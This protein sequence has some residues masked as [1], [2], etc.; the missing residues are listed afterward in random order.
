MPLTVRWL[1]DHRTEHYGRE[2][3]LLL[4]TLATPQSGQPTFTDVE[5]DQVRICD[6]RDASGGAWAN[7]PPAGT[8]A[9]DPALGRVYFG[10]ALPTGTVPVASYHAGLAV[11]VGAR[12][13]RRVPPGERP[14]ALGLPTA[15]PS[16]EVLASG[17]GDLTQELAA[18]RGGGT[19]RIQD[20]SRWTTPVTI[21]TDDV[22]AGQPAVTVA[23]VSDATARPVIDDPK[24]I[25]L[26]MAPGSTVV[27]DGLMVSAGPVVLEETGQDQ[28]RTVILRDCTLVPGLDRT[29]TGLPT[30]PERASLIVL[31]PFATVVLD[32]CV[33]GPVVAVEGC[34]V[35]VHSCVVDAGSPT[36]VALAGRDPG[37]GP[38]AD[39]HAGRPG[40]RRRDR[41]VGRPAGSR[42]PPWS[43]G[44]TSPA[45]TAPTPCCWPSSRPATH[46]PRRCGRSAARSG[47]CGTHGS[48]PSP[49][50]GDASGASPTRRRLGA[51]GKPCARC[52]PRCGSGTRRTC[53]CR[54]GHRP[55]IRRGAEDEGEMGATHDLYAP[56]REDDLV[57]RLEEYLRFG[58]EAGIFYAT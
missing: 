16:P 25:R 48:R 5:L 55:P 22:P 17:G 6:L 9:V 23:L 12:T 14:A 52:S 51:P 36:A 43:A 4:E 57:V 50:P 41:R 39:P 26:D 46:D 7:Q 44:C 33:T 28:P 30:S 18:V 13:I 42:P 34:Q 58:L 19:V 35:H 47:A 40:G 45:W 27:L 15:Y 32:G 31:D 54:P 1:S 37:S 10:T 21:T 3:S 49:G 56:L 53:R 24:G 20:S 38:R 29:P 2:R 8:V 11:P